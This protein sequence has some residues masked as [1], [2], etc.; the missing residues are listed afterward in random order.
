MA[1]A[2]RWRLVSYDVRD[3]GRWRRVY[4][5]LRG[6]GKP[7]QYSVFRCR[8]DEREMQRLR[9]ELAKVMTKDD[10]LLVV[11]LCPSCVQRVVTSGGDQEWTIEEPT[12]Q[13]YPLPSDQAPDGDRGADGENEG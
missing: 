1:V 6:A 13:I 4:R 8:L 10:R 7:L 12:F 11:D 3:P 5:L 9:W 2:K